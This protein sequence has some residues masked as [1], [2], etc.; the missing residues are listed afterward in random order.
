MS[1]NHAC[2][3]RKL[4]LEITGRHA[5]NEQNTYALYRDDQRVEALA[6][7]RASEGR[8]GPIVETADEYLEDELADVRLVQ[9]VGDIEIE[10]LPEG[11]V[12][13]TGLV[14][15]RRD[16]Q[17]H[18]MVSCVPMQYLD[19]EEIAA[20]PCRG[21]FL[22][23]FLDGRLIRE[24]AIRVEPGKA[25]VFIDS[26]V[27]GYRRQ[28][29]VPVVREYTGP[30]LSNLHL[31]LRLDGETADVRLAYSDHPW[32]WAHVIE[33]EAEPTRIGQRAQPLPL[34]TTAVAAML[35]GNLRNQYEY[36]LEMG[37]DETQGKAALEW[38][39]PMRERDPLYEQARGSARDYLEDVSGERWAG[40][41]QQL[42]DERAFF[43]SDEQEASVPE[44]D[45]RR[46]QRDFAPALRSTLVQQ[47]NNARRSDEDR[48]GDASLTLIPAPESGEDVLAPLRDQ[49]LCAI[50]LRD[51][52][53]AVDQ[54]I[55][56]IQAS[57]ELLWVLSE[58]MKYHPHGKSAELV[59]A[60]CFMPNGP[61]GQENPVYLDEWF[62]RR[63]DRSRESLFARLTKEEE[64]RLTRLRIDERLTSLVEMLEDA[65]PGAFGAALRDAMPFDDI[66]HLEPY[67]CLSQ[68]LDPLM[69]GMDCLDPKANPEEADT[70]QAPPRCRQAL[71]AL[72][73]E[74]SHP[75]AYLLFAPEN[76]KDDGW[77][78][79]YARDLTK[80]TQGGTRVADQAGD[81]ATPTGD[82]LIAHQQRLDEEAGDLG[83]AMSQVRTALNGTEAVATA[84]L[85]G[86]LT[87][88]S[89]NKLGE[90]R[91]SLTLAS[92]LADLKGAMMG[93]LP[94]RVTDRNGR[95]VMMLPDEIRPLIEEMAQG[96]VA[97]QAASAS[98]ALGGE[99]V[100]S[101]AAAARPHRVS[102]QVTSEQAY[103][104][105]QSG[106]IG[107]WSGLA[108]LETYNLVSS[109]GDALQKGTAEN[110]LKAASA[111][112]DASLLT[113]QGLKLANVRWGWAIQANQ[114]L[115]IRF[116]T[117][118]DW[119]RAMGQAG[120]VRGGMAFGAGLFTATLVA[121]DAYQL[122]Q[123]GLKDSAKW[124][125]GASG[126][127]AVGSYV[128]SGYGQG[129]ANAARMQLVRNRFLN[130]LLGL[131]GTPRPVPAMLVSLGVALVC[132]YMATN[133]RDDR[134]S[135]WVRYGPFGHERDELA[136]RLRDLAEDA[137]GDARQADKR[138]Y[139]ASLRSASPNEAYVQLLQG[140]FQAHFELVLPRGLIDID[141]RF[142]DCDIAIRLT[143]PALRY[144]EF[145]LSIPHLMAGYSA[146]VP[147]RRFTYQYAP[148]DR[149]RLLVE[150]DRRDPD[151]PTVRYLGLSLPEKWRRMGVPRVPGFGDVPADWLAANQ[152]S[153]RHEPEFQNAYHRGESLVRLRLEDVEGEGTI[154]YWDPAERKHRAL[155]DRVSLLAQ[156]ASL[157]WR[158]NKQGG[159]T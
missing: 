36:G 32:P 87:A 73:L 115:D 25:P 66:N 146:P 42:E 24:L 2:R 50:F 102:G 97:L 123:R 137:E 114:F 7:D 61:D 12:T 145:S 95:I 17:H 82:A 140:L 64:R 118:V 131:V 71:D 105:T 15:K 103:R 100:A 143:C 26:D 29:E 81:V 79:T 10:L 52:K 147:D 37:R 135:L 112:I 49:Q 14:P 41:V 5:D 16:F 68:C 93:G 74:A 151:D 4:Y 157:T 57:Q 110:L 153:F 129:L 46:R 23:V 55:G 85:P 90:Q 19:H 43:E 84:V 67:A 54:L 156:P 144:G 76:R 99:A 20:G 141:P 69:A 21:G 152:A 121:I 28:G 149:R 88:W 133:S 70:L 62:D 38:L 120:Q 86:L 78:A 58:G 44:I 94:I 159:R 130:G 77:G 136:G 125:A 72:F 22:Y 27:A 142:R 104:W 134:F 117:D 116:I 60:N 107:L 150:A 127:I 128:G 56:D 34:N 39:P 89:R 126:A 108:V 96:G 148:M 3:P 122:S 65:S 48:A 101:S 106:Y 124:T 35:D 154:D 113:L 11:E 111:T 18:L 45:M 98:N 83:L 75:L 51:P 30:E 1:S 132:Q 155:N 109:I 40:L 80:I 8:Y 53:L 91:I 92:D 33:L 13:R 139:L 31:P 59:L 47:W 138:D 158:W 63:L 6:E 119:R 9:C